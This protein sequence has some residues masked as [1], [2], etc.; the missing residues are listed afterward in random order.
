MKF[1]RQTG[2]LERGVMWVPNKVQLFDNTRCECSRL[3][4]ISNRASTYFKQLIACCTTRYMSV[5]VW[6]FKRQT[7]DL[8]RGVMWVQNKV[9]TFTDTCYG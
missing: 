6:K 3:C 8:E 7:S 9:K 2:D 5:Q 1:K 4:Y